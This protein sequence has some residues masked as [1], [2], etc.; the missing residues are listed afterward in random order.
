MT[1]RLISLLLCFSPFLFAQPAGAPDSTFGNDGIAN[2]TLT[3]ND[4]LHGITVIDIHVLP[5]QKI[6]AA[7]IAKNGCSST[8]NEFGIVFR[9]N[10]DGSLDT[11]FNNTG[12]RLFHNYFFQAIIATDNDTFFVVSS[13]HLLKMNGNGE[14]DTSFGTDGFLFFNMQASKA[15]LTQDGKI[16]LG[17]R[18]MNPSAQ[19]ELAATRVNTNGTIDT[20]F[21]S[22]GIFTIP[23]VSGA[24]T[25][26]GGMHIDD[27]NRL[28]LVGRRQVS[29]N[30]GKIIAFRLLENG[31]YDPTFANDGTYFENIHHNARAQGIHTTANG[32]IIIAG[33]GQTGPFEN[34]GLILIQLNNNGTLN[35]EFAT[36]GRLLQPIYS[37]STA[38]ALHILDDE[39]IVVTGG[40]ES[41][42]IAKF[43]TQGTPITDFGTNGVVNNFHFDWTGF[44]TGS[45][46][47]GNRIILI[48]NTAFAHCSQ[49]KYEALFV[50]HFLDDQGISI[51]AYPAMNL[52]SCDTSANGNQTASF[53]L[54]I[55]DENIIFGQVGTT[56]SYHLTTNDAL[57]GTN[58][59]ENPETFV[60]TS[61]AQ[62]IFARIQDGL[63]NFDTT[64]FALF[65][66]PLPLVVEPNALTS[67][68]TNENGTALFQLSDRTFEITGGTP[69]I[70]VTYHLT[71][72]AAQNNTQALPNNYQ[73]TV[74]YNQTVFARAE[75]NNTGCFS[76]VALELVVNPIPVVPTTINP[77]IVCSESS[78]TTF[79]L[80]LRTA[81]IYGSQSATDFE[82]W[83]YSTL[84][85]AQ[86]NTNAIA[87]P[88]A[89]ENISSPE[90]IFIRLENITTGCFVTT[91]FDLILAQLYIAV[92]PQDIYIDEGDGDGIALFD[93][94]I[95]EPVMLGTQNA[96]DISFSYFES[97]TDAEN[98]T[99]EILNPEQFVNTTNPQT[100]FVRMEQNQTTDCFFISSFE[101]ETDEFLSNQGPNNIQVSLYPNPVKSNLY[102]T[103]PNTIELVEVFN[104]KG[105]KLQL[106]ENNL[107]SNQ[108]SID[109]SDLAAGVYLV[110]MT[111]NKGV[112][113]KRVIKQ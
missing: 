61:N 73:N 7:G 11:T 109:F 62:T 107:D 23:H 39:S 66:N 57:N 97:L 54:T 1:F 3:I 75:N 98:N 110:K 90:T 33:N 85:D 100:I 65:V 48:A 36:D 51:T 70:T 50:R 82:L 29:Q 78:N 91:S 49:Q 93:L 27:E 25:A 106:P 43:D 108:K 6:L 24:S 112:V 40:Y 74:P 18:K 77:I 102:L 14:P 81:E 10:S 88:T 113:V 35:T 79:D 8:S 4:L 58:V 63:G 80:T 19:W 9:L 53:D 34:H 28:L 22:N 32:N 68:D 13:N 101:I 12:Y 95:N 5:G 67:C 52:T 59:I 46:V 21:G 26:F 83:F 56:V 84:N 31:T 17:G 87:T 37:E 103:T 38:V 104:L 47:T 105:Q 96:N 2:H 69:D 30:N 72:A 15:M 45:V 89:Y 86:N 71:L 99:N 76:T 92:M 64:S 55:N 44:N 20:N 42:Y 16:M 111:T 94:T 60:N 41:T